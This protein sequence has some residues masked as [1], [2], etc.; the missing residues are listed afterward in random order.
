[1]AKLFFKVASDVDKVIHLRQEITRLKQELT[2]IDVNKAP[3]AAKALQVQLGAATQEFT[4]LTSEAGRAGAV[5]GNDLK[6]KIFQGSQAVNDFTQKITNQKVVIRDIESDVRRLTDAYRSV[7]HNPL[8]G[9]NALGE[10]N[11]AKKALQEEKAALFGL[12]TEQSNARLSVKK[13]RDE[14]ALYRD[15]SKDTVQI[16]GGIGISLK[17]AFAVIGGAAA[18]KEL[19]S[20]MIRVRGEFQAADTAIQTLLGS[21]EKADTLMAQVKEYAKI[22]P[23]EFSDV[24]AAT[25]MMLGFNIEADKAPRFIRAIGDISMGEAGKF[26]SLTLAFSQMSA[27]GKLMGQDLNQMINAGFNP[28]QQ[29]ATSTGK[30]IAVLKEEMSKGAISAEMVQQAFIDATSAGGKFFGMSENASKT[31]NGQLSMLQDAIDS[32]LNEMGEKSEGI[33]MGSIQLTTKLVENY[34]TAGKVIA[35]LVATYGAYR[36]A[37][38]LSTLTTGKHTLAEVALINVRVMARRAQ[39]ALNASMLANPFV[40]LTTAVVGVAAAMWAMHDSTT[41]AER[42]QSRFNEEKDRAIKREEAHK[43]H[44]D[45][46]ISTMQSETEAEMNRIAAMEQLKA[47]YPHIFAKYVDEKGHLRDLIGYRKEIA[48]FDAKVSV[49]TAERQANRAKQ[50]LIEVNKEINY[51]SGSTSGATK[52]FRSKTTNELKEMQSELLK[53]YQL[54]QKAYDALAELENKA[55]E[56][57]VEKTKDKKYWEAQKSNA[58]SALAALSNVEASGKKGLELKKQ[59][60]EY[61]GKLS[62]FS[63]SSSKQESKEERLR[64]QDD[65][66]SDIAEKNAREQ[67]RK[68]EDVWN[69]VWQSQIDAMAEGGDK[70]IAQMEL[71]HEKELQAIDRE[72]DDLIQ[73]Y[74][75]AAKAEFDAK[76]NAKKIENPKYKTKSFDGSGISLSSIDTTQLDEKY[77]AALDRQAKA[78][79]EYY[80]LET[81]AMNEYLA[82]YGTYQE[83]RNAIIA[84]GEEKKKGKNDWEKKSIDQETSKL[85]A[86]VDD[87]AQRKTSIITKLFSDMSRRTVKD[88][89]LI[90]DEAKSMLDYVNGGEFKADSKGAGL[91]GITKE[92]F[93]ILSKSPEKLESIKNEISNVTKEADVAEDALGKMATGLKKVFSSNPV[94]FKEGLANLSDGMSQLTQAGQ[95]LSDS[96]SSLGDAFGSGTLSGIADGINV[97]MDAMSS[98]MDGAKAGAAFGPWGAAAGAAIGMVSSLASSFAKIHDA[99]NEKRIQVLQEQIEVLDKGYEKLGSSIDKAYSKDASKLISQQNKMLEQQKIL[100]RNQIRE[101][102]DKKSTDNGRIK[103]WQDQIEEINKLIGDNKEK[104]IDAIFGEDL[105]S[106]IENF[107]QSYA[108]AWKSNEDKAKSAKDTVKTMMRQMVEESIKAAIHSSNSMEKIRAKLQEFYADNVLSGWEQDYI[109]KMADELQKELDEK[110]GWADGLMNDNK[111]SSQGSTNGG[112]QTMSQDTGSELNGRFTALQ[113]SNESI[114]AQSAMQTLSISDI[115]FKSGEIL[116]VSSEMRNIADETRTLLANVLLEAAQISEN[117]GEIIKPIREMAKDIAEVKRNTSK[118]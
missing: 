11:A 111:A 9:S 117:T 44:I 65:K 13:L 32:S 38:M 95:F 47:A 61:D 66:A 84:N 19:I 88:I 62:A 45:R 6:T 118:L 60:A 50:E 41:A 55:K 59:I 69:Q 22:S 110:F 24:T 81:K 113:I 106:A 27:T 48:E 46:L 71:N 51:R 16:N 42:A 37:V 70:T 79:K 31:I 108:D 97:A 68:T 102:Q 39:L 98:T 99:K 5:L 35:G 77:K 3:A 76:E 63:T 25:Q 115:A 116:R 30:S 34:E 91:F 101:E 28:L 54:K 23:L 73:K 15:E 12:Q 105:K 72:K 26:N 78:V 36:T 17:K 8:Q 94:K 92:Q 49:G 1:M 86:G 52:R 104:Q 75:E 4:K 58:E 90:A 21:K 112:F 7:R 83:K 20:S 93:D 43:A 96:L 14:Y 80:A 100:I 33:I 40:L 2:S 57:P 10:L 18:G 82:E 114:L 107:A 53:E 89:R 74:K 56:I 29:I 87:E 103:E 64:K 67:V 109:Y 85:L